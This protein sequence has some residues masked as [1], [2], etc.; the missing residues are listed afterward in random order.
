MFTFDT[1]K[2]ASNQLKKLLT[3]SPDIL[4]CIL[5]DTQTNTYSIVTADQ[6]DNEYINRIGPEKRYQFIYDNNNP[7]QFYDR[8]I[9]DTALEEIES[10]KTNTWFDRDLTF[11]DLLYTESGKCGKLLSNSTKVPNESLTAVVYMAPDRSVL[12]LNMC[13]R[14]GICK[15]SCIRY[16]GHNGIETRSHMKHNMHITERRTIALVQYSRRFLCTMLKELH[17]LTQLK[18][19]PVK[20]FRGNGSTDTRWEKL[21]KMRLLN[22]L[23]GILFYD[24]TKLDFDYRDIEGIKDIYKL[25]YSLDENRTNH[26]LNQAEKYRRAGFSVAIAIS[27]DDHKSIF[28]PDY[29]QHWVNASNQYVPLESDRRVINGDLSDNRYLDSGNVILLKY[30]RPTGQ[31]SQPV[32]EKFL[33]TMNHLISE[34]FVSMYTSIFIN[35]EFYMMSITETECVK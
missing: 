8:F 17:R 32:N 10:W 12:G 2:K 5:F 1:Q 29:N 34:L 19:D 14:A 26:K 4:H 20:Y 33:F 13:L 24:Y 15:F 31:Y 3:E 28:D 25:T 21:L 27:I 9:A 7:I 18:K 6:F 22:I 11:E 35:Y 23:L 16:T 30:K